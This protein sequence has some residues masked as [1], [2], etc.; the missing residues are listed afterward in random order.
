MIEMLSDICFIFK[1]H[2]SKGEHFMQERALIWFEVQLGSGVPS[3]QDFDH[4][5]N[6]VNES[7]LEGF[8]TSEH[9]S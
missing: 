6:F 5:A 2:R 1:P 9:I 3:F 8:L 4:G 7:S